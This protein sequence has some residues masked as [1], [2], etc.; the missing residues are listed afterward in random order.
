M[1]RKKQKIRILGGLTNFKLKKDRNG[2]ETCIYSGVDYAR[3]VQPLKYLPRDEFQVDIE[4]DLYHKYKSIEELT[5]HYDIMLYSYIHNPKLYIELKV[6]GMRNGMKLVLDLDDDIWDV[7]PTHPYYKDDYHPG[8]ENMFNRSAIILDTDKVITTNQ[9]LKYKIVENT[10]RSIKDIDIFPNYI[11]LTM[12][13]YKKI[14]V[15][16]HDNFVIGYMGGSSHYPDINKPEFTKA[17]KIIMD[18]YPNVRLK[19]TF[20]MPQ[21]KALFGYKYQ[22]ALGRYDILKFIDE[23]WPKMASECDIFVAPLRWSKYSRSKSYI[24]YLEY[25]ASK[26]PCIME[27]IDPYNEVLAGHEERGLQA[28]STEDW[29]KHL[30]YLIE[31]PDKRKQMGEE[32]YKYIK[33]NHTIQKN[34]YKYADYFRKIFDDIDSKIIKG[35]DSSVIF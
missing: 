24:K 22:Y 8:S 30:S 15:K 35:I 6:C 1:D 23:L 12:Y 29:V 17:M 16:K 20:Y 4:Y 34:A 28:S 11:D 19:T 10:S 3:L 25:S 31:N 26:I 9:F 33:E 13:D 18:K 32:G 21:L 2:K 14:P 5:K 27:K 7:D